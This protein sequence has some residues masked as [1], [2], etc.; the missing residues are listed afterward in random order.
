MRCSNPEWLRQSA[1]TSIGGARH[2]SRAAPRHRAAWADRNIRTQ[3]K[4]AR[5]VIQQWAS[6]RPGCTSASI[7]SVPANPPIASAW[8][9]EP[10]SR[11]AVGSPRRC[12]HGSRR[13]FVCIA[14]VFGSCDSA[15]I[16]G[17]TI[18]AEP[19]ARRVFGPRMADGTCAARAFGAI[20]FVA[21]AD[22]RDLL[23]CSARRP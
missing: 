15:A 20:R 2:G 12:R 22:G 21:P 13:A 14:G 23:C 16:A 9:A 1:S 7:V 17:G 11:A 4:I 10:A 3:D 18:C 5:E 19:Q 8:F 6:R